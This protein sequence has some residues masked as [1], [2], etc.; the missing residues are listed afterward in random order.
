MKKQAP[1]KSGSPCAP[2]ELETGPDE[3][4]AWQALTQF[5][6]ALDWLEPRRYERGS[7]YMN[8]YK[9]QIAARL[10]DFMTLGAYMRAPNA[11]GRE[12]RASPGLACVS[13]G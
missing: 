2:V 13:R 7:S 10:K 1:G 4:R 3:K 12:H 8:L 9:T 6:E 5:A 11:V